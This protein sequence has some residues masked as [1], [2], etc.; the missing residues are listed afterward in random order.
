MIVTTTS[1]SIE[2]SLYGWLT[3]SI[4]RPSSVHAR[5]IHCTALGLLCRPEPGGQLPYSQLVEAVASE[6]EV[7][8]LR[9]G[10]RHEILQVDLESTVVQL[11]A[12]AEQ[13]LGLV[14]TGSHRLQWLWV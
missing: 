5:E 13:G 14:G 7:D 8:L 11:R 2:T 6:G 3:V 12:Q 10:R 9:N 1:D 4:D